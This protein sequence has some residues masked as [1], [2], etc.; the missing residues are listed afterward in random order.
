VADISIHWA[1]LAEVAE[2]SLLFGVGI[3]VVFALGVI[4]LSKFEQARAGEGSASTRAGGFALAG[5][6][7]LV[8]AAAV[9]YGLYLI[10]PQFHNR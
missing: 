4:G 6:A 9:A 1:G 10:I 2:V 7:F 3:V 5:T 8:C